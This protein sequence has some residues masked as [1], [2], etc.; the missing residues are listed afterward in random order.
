MHEKHEKESN[1]QLFD[2]QSY[3][4]KN[5]FSQE[6]EEEEAEEEYNEEK[7]DENYEQQH[8][9]DENL[10]EEMEM[11]INF[12]QQEKE[13]SDIFKEECPNEI[14]TENFNEEETK[15]NKPERE[16]KESMQAYLKTEIHEE[17]SIKDCIFETG[18]MAKDSQLL[19][20]EDLYEKHFISLDSICEKTDKFGKL[21]REDSFKDK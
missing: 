14:E 11:E 15:I 18:N 16:S 7:L 1:Q 13:N 20:N 21:Q 19:L 10:E 3:E 4:S 17:K 6:Q 9:N 8:E 5:S 2:F 12:N